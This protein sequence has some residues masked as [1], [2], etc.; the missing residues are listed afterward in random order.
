MRIWGCDKWL[1]WVDG[2]G[3]NGWVWLVLEKGWAGSGVSRP[4]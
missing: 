4:L 3:I 2:S 1:D